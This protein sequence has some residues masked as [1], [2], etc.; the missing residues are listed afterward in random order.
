MDIFEEYV[1]RCDELWQHWEALG[2]RV[3]SVDDINRIA[4]RELM[5]K[6]IAIGKPESLLTIIEDEPK[7]YTD[8]SEIDSI[9]DAVA[10]KRQF[11]KACQL[12]EKVLVNLEKQYWYGLRHHR[13][14]S[15]RYQQPIDDP[16]GNRILLY[17]ETR[18]LLVYGYRRYSSLI[19]K[20][21]GRSTTKLLKQLE[22]RSRLVYQEALPELVIV[23]DARPMTEAVF[24]ELIETTRVANP[25]DHVDKLGEKLRGFAP[26]E[27]R[28]FAKILRNLVKDANSWDLWGAAFLLNDGCSDD[29][30][31]DFRAWLILQ[32]QQKFH[33]SAAHPDS[34]ADWAKPDDPLEA[35]A[36]L[37]L[38]E[39]IYEEVTGKDCPT[40]EVSTSRPKGK[41]WREDE[42][43]T[44]L[45]RLAKVCG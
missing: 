25:D 13:R 2:T 27:I 16:E 32:G 7:S 6:Y 4:R 9:A 28:Q 34:M 14:K 11:K 10:E 31:L 41:R 3:N 40:G 18:V 24:W 19:H 23:P 15:P 42:L 12:W 20:H 22:E 43:P 1:R 39:E 8:I 37:Y 33:H 30:F 21:G 29:A 5:S 26:K 35:E 45:P 36:L 38:A 44:R 17:E